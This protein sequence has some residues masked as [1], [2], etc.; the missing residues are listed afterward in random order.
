MVTSLSLAATNGADVAVNLMPLF[1][2]MMKNTSLGMTMPTE[3]WSPN[4]E[5]QVMDVAK[6]WSDNLGEYRKE[7]FEKQK[8]NGWVKD[9]LSFVVQDSVYSIP[10]Y[11][12]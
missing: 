11:N 1:Y 5:Q 8:D 3:F 10:A 4:T 2:N 12:I 9:I 7:L 6:H